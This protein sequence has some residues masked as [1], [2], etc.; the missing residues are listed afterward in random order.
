M[1]IQLFFI[2]SFFNPPKGGLLRRWHRR[3][4]HVSLGG[5]LT[6][7]RSVVLLVLISLLKVQPAE[8]A[9]ERLAKETCK[10]LA[11]LLSAS[12]S[13][14]RRHQVTGFQHLKSRLEDLIPVVLSVVGHDGI[15]RLDVQEVLENLTSAVGQVFG[16]HLLKYLPCFPMSL[17]SALGDLVYWQVVPADPP[18][19]LA[20]LVQQNCYLYRLVMLE[21]I[22]FCINNVEILCIPFLNSLHSCLCIPCLPF[23]HVLWHQAPSQSLL[24]P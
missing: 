24:I 3:H 17:S 15:I 22:G 5:G 8:Q 16:T 4:L 23:L 14:F 18:D 11:H 9:I 19:F 20:I 1:S 2:C 13:L 7:L 12:P 10:L 6:F 21:A